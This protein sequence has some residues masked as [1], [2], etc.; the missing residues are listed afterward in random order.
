MRTDKILVWPTA[1]WLIFGPVLACMWIAAVNYANNLVYAILY[2]VGSLSFVSLFHTWR[3]LAALRVEH[4]RI[5]PAFA[6]EDV[7]VEAHLRNV[8]KYTIYGLLFARYGEDVAGP[9]RPISWAHPLGVLEW[10]RSRKIAP[11]RLADGRG[12]RV[13]GEDTCA[14][15]ASFSSE[16]RGL[17]RFDSLVVRTSYPFGLFSA[18]IRLPVGAEYFVYPKPA[19]TGVWPSLQ[20]GGETGVPNHLKVGDDFAGVR[21]Y[22]P[23]ESL[24]HVDWKAFA[25]GRPLSV[26]QFTG[27]GGHELWLD[28]AEMSRLPLEARLSQ[29][30]L[31]VVNAEKEEIPYAL[32]MGRTTLPLGL[33]PAQ[34]RRALET[35]AVAGAGSS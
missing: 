13:A 34:M 14:V 4:I 16:R 22:M 12:V 32:K 6:G 24:R 9:A 31:W 5:Q 7:C 21:A 33:G 3:N 17:Y 27:G 10:F 8:S 30:A 26:K 29:L 18:T 11:L 15:A 35:L 23:G 28:A 25:R 1:L 19:G 20:P 2:L